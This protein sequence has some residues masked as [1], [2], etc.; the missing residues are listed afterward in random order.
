[1]QV[2]LFQ[3][4]NLLILVLQAQLEIGQRLIQPGIAGLFGLQGGEGFLQGLVF[5]SQRQALDFV[6]LVEFVIGF[7]R[8][9]QPGFKGFALL[10]ELFASLID[11]LLRLF[12]QALC[13]A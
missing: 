6:L 9:R 1:M 4:A 13:Q 10:L 2:F 7:L 8:F 5:L 3:R 11:R 12:F